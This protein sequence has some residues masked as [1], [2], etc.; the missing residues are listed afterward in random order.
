VLANVPAGPDYANEMV[1]D[2]VRHGGGLVTLGGMH[3]YGS[4]QWAET[5]LADLL[6]VTLQGTFDLAR[7]RH[8]VKPASRDPLLAGI[9]WPKNAR[10]YWVHPET[11][12]PGSRTVLTA[13]RRPLVVLGPCGEGRVACL[14]ATCH[15]EALPG[16]QEAW[17]TAAWV[18][19]LS[20]VLGW[21]IGK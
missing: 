13:G 12:K 15:G 11:P 17:R 21:T 9:A 16:Q 10:F 18:A 19:M 5:P 20:R 14:L 6:P 2:F 1:A 4:G 3:S 8:G 7:E